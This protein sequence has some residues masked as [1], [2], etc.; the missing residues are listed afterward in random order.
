MRSHKKKERQKYDKNVDRRT[1]ALTGRPADGQ[2]L[3]LN[4]VV[5]QKTKYENKVKWQTESRR[6]DGRMYDFLKRGENRAR[7]VPF[8]ILMRT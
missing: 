2:N 7:G 4:R 1:N 6:T 5:A 8:Q 3:L